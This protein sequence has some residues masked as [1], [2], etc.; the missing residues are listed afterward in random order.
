MIWKRVQMNRAGLNERFVPLNILD[1]F[2][3]LAIIP[4]VRSGFLPPAGSGR[5]D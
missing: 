3:E 5:G 4:L 1:Y 2:A